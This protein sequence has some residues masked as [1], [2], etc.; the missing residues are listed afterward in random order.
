[1]GEKQLRQTEER[2]RRNFEE[3]KR[4]EGHGDRNRV[5]GKI[6]ENKIDG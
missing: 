4:G 1:M 5:R 6:K 2:V 3:E